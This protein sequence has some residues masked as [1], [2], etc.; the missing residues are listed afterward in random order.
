[1]D[2][3]DVVSGDPADLGPVFLDPAV[4][5]PAFVPEVLELVKASGQGDRVKKRVTNG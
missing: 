1:M 5:I 2:D 4:R 3:R